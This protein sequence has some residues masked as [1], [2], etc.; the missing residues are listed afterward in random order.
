M[1][2]ICEASCLAKPVAL[3]LLG[4]TLQIDHFVHSACLNR[5]EF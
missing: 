4:I 2:K 1:V 3:P 5:K